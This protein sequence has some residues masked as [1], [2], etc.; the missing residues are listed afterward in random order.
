MHVEQLARIAGQCQWNEQQI[1]EI[2]GQWIAVVPEPQVSRML[3]E[4]SAKHAW[5]ANLW[6]ERLPAVRELDTARFVAP[7]TP[8]MQA[9]FDAV[10]SPSA[11]TQTIEKLA[12]VYRVVIPRLAKG[13]A[14]MSRHVS[15]EIDGPTARVLSLV[16]RDEQDDWREGEALLQGLLIGRDEV[17]RANDHQVNVETLMVAAEQ[18]VLAG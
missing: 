16:L 5:H 13:Y 11:P 6:A 15:A 12:G 3:A 1:F 2:I 7:A 14:A 18:A 8:L 9:V 10:R 4:H 17:R